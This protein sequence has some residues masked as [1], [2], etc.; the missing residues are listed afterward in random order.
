MTY[1]TPKGAG[2]RDAAVVGAELGMEYVTVA[3]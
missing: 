3:L 2:S 1:D